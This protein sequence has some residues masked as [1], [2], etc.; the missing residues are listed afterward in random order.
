MVRAGRGPARKRSPELT[1]D[2]RITQAR[3]ARD[4]YFSPSFATIAGFNANGAMPHYHATSASHA[5]ICDGRQAGN[6]LLLIDS[7]GQYQSGTP[8]SPG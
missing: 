7:G 4:D 2:E 1:I 3:A 6:G 5:V 8:T